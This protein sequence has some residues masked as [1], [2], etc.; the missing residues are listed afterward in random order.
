[1]QEKQMP[2]VLAEPMR[3]Q[4]DASDPLPL[5]LQRGSGCLGL[6]GPWR[7]GLAD[8]RVLPWATSP[9]MEG[10]FHEAICP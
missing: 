2:Q 10:P 4:L 5:P 6:V 8:M 9:G 3:C 1:M 7:R